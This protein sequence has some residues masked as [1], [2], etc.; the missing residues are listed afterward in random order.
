MLETICCHVTISAAA[1]LQSNDKLAHCA[2]IIEAIVALLANDLLQVF[3]I[4]GQHQTVTPWPKRCIQSDNIPVLRPLHHEQQTPGNISDFAL[5]NIQPLLDL[6]QSQDGIQAKHP[7]D[8][9]LITQS[10][11]SEPAAI[12]QHHDWLIAV[13]F[14][15]RDL[16]SKDCCNHLL[17][18]C[19]LFL[20]HSMEALQE[21][22]T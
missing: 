15:R 9:G 22:P 20:H 1:F 12:S 13:P 16:R 17:C 18:T 21:T 6:T 4:R 3:H 14:P 19:R 8:V 5:F 10:M 7:H 2:P 11:Q